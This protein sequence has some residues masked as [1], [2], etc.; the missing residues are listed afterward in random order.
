MLG[1]GALA[2]PGL[3]RA[4]ATELGL[5][6]ATQAEPIDWPRLTRGLC[7][8]TERVRGPELQRTPR[9]IK[10]WLKYAFDRGTFHAFDDIKRVLDQ[11]ELLAAIE[12]RVSRSEDRPKHQPRE[13]SG[14]DTHPHRH[15]TGFGFF[16][17]RIVAA[18][19]A[20]G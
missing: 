1:R 11:E 16:I 9:R 7:D 4:I 6:P 19:R 8:W 14:E 3:P 12:T 18:R 20:A 15:R 5:M 10:Q 17:A 2:D 13:D